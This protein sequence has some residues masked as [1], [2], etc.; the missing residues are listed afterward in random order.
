MPD[1]FNIVGEKEIDNLTLANSRCWNYV[2][3]KLYYE[4]VDFHAARPGHD[5]RY[6]L[7]GTKIAESR[8]EGSGRLLKSLFARRSSGRSKIKNG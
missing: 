1:A 7:D 8:L 5:R 4:L 3:K 6:A 2:G